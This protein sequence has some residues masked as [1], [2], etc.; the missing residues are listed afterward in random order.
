MVATSVARQQ[1]RFAG[2]L[3]E[4]ADARQIKDRL[5]EKRRCQ[6]LSLLVFGQALRLDHSVPLH[7]KF[8]DSIL[9]WSNHG[10][11]EAIANRYDLLAF[12][13]CLDQFFKWSVDR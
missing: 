3:G 10:E 6:R 2:S 4:H 8:F 13:G 1:H 11:L 5:V 12:H 9:E 7:L